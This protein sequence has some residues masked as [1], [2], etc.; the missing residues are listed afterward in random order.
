[1]EAAKRRRCLRIAI[2]ANLAALLAI[3][4]YV[5]I[6]A[7]PP[8]EAVRLRNALLIEAGTDADF[9]WTPAR[10]PANFM[11]ERRAPPR[12][13]VAI[14]RN[15][16]AD[17]AA[18]DWA[19][20]LAYA[21]T[22]TANARDRGAIQ[23][24]LVTTYRAIVEEG[25]GYCA[26]FVDAYMA[27]AHAGAL[28][29]RQW[30]FSFDGF[31]GH[32]HAFV[33]VFDRS[34]GKWVFLDVYNNVHA[35]DRATGKPL[36]ALEFRDFVLGRGTDAEIRRNGPGRL[37]FRIEQKLLDYYRKG[38]DEW[39]LWWGNNV[40]SYYEHPAVRAAERIA[41]PLAQLTAIAVGVHPGIKVLATPTNAERL[42]AMLHLRS[43]LLALA[44]VVVILLVTLAILLWQLRREPG[45]AR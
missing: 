15:A 27:L 35:V 33:E 14:T 22:L 9:S 16:Q 32:G 31:G 23:S 29:T 7:Y 42:N 37:G 6:Q 40:F 43:V 17:A 11:L 28:G 45:T 3:A 18:S 36:S 24:D 41:R 30:G 19:K 34:L 26:D 2:A 21:G 5:L 44:V 25:R 8:T 39:Y 4:T 38:A 12:E 13:F 20:A 1:M 10:P